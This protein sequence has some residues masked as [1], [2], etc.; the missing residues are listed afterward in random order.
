MVAS[1]GGIIINQ[2]Y[3]DN[4]GG[5]EFDTDGDGTTT[6]E[7]EFV[8]VQNTTG[9]AI[10]LSGWE[11]WSDMSGAGAPD[12]PQD[13]LYH[14]FPPGTVLNPG[15][16]LYIVNEITGTPASNMQEAS[17]GGVE[18]GAGGANTNF[19][20]E[21]DTGNPES[22]ALVN[23]STGDYIIINLSGTD[24][25]GI[26]SLSGFPGTNLLGESNAATDSGQEDQNAG[27]SYQYNATTDSYE[28]QTV[29]V[30]CFAAGTLIDLPGGVK[31]VEDVV[32]G[33]L[34]TTLDHGPQ[35][36]RLSLRRKLDFTS[37]D[38]ERHKPIE[39]KQGALG[40]GLPIRRLVVSPQHQILVS[41]PG[42]PQVF[43]PAKALAAY[44]RGIRVMKGRRQVC[45]HHLVFE[46]PEI[47]RAEGVWSESFRPGPWMTSTLA[48]GLA[49]NL[50]RL[51]PGLT[52]GRFPDPARTS[53]AAG[54]AGTLG[55]CRAY[56]PIAS[57]SSPV[58][59]VK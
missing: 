42:Q 13:G 49:K 14:T 46:K 55:T 57:V 48:P 19:L 56:T 18:S 35:P 27:S 6:Q 9:S 15:R 33:D 12:G 52:Q 16:T 2:I 5:A 25:S 4:S 20:T 11:V 34:V 24:P 50:H 40:A 54:K 44:H 23:P 26:P 45:Y 41:T 59:V 31:L 53:I 22:I 38:S 10:D 8:S 58:R 36:L 17:E 32:P 1:L 7:D 47:V 29:T 51:Y 39:I 43:V 28:Y 21:G 3:G 37:G 30:A